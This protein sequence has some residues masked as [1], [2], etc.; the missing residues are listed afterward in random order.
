M[1]D[2]KKINKN[3]PVPLYYQ[4]KEILR[5]FIRNSSVDDPIPTESELCEQFEV[6]RPT[7]RQAINELVSEGYLRRNKGKGTFVT[8]PKVRR[9]FLLALES[10]NTEMRRRGIKPTT[11]VLALEITE[12][13]QLVQEKLMLNQNDPVVFLRRLRFADGQPLMIVNSFLPYARFPGFENFDFETISLHS[14]IE[15]NYPVKLHRALRSIEAIACSPEEALHLDIEPN[16]PVQYLET[17]VY[18]TD[19]WPVEFSTA[20]YRGDRSRFT[21]ELGRGELAQTL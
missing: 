21:V 9:D 13:D 3:T 12:P 11:R 19:G 18:A 4:L 8:Q 17:L 7:V 14:A 15:K 16:T 6:S 20:W 2:K 1:L 5:E 10:F